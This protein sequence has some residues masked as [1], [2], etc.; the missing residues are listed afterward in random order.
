MRKKKIYLVSFLIKKMG[1]RHYFVYVEASSKKEARAKAEQAWYDGHFAHMFH[2]DVTIPEVLP[3]CY[4]L[5]G[6]YRVREY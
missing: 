1:E 6:F 2:I 4:Y 5:Y 3:E